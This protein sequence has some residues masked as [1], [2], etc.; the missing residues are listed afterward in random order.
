M[1]WALE[2]NMGGFLGVSKGS[3]QAPIFLE[4]SY[5]GTNPE[6]QPLV[7]VGKGVTFDRYVTLF[8][9]A[10]GQFLNRFKDNLSGLQNVKVK[11]FL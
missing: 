8:F 6:V 4:M 5:T 11:D 7:L 10:I 1:H 9:K 3:D 2:K